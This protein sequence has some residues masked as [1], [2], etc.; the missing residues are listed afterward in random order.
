MIR[1]VPCWLSGV[2]EQVLYINGRA[3]SKPSLS[4]R[5]LALHN[6][7]TSRKAT[8]CVRSVLQLIL[9]KEGE[10]EALVC[11]GII[12]C[13]VWE[14]L[15]VL[16]GLVDR[17]FIF[18]LSK[19]MYSPPLVLRRLKMNIFFFFFNLENCA[20]KFTWY[21]WSLMVCCQWRPALF[22]GLCKLSALPE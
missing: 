19:Q 22:P 20:Y 11:I 13:W 15:F 2:P 16:W 9:S 10:V 8:V 4:N 12:L 7:V 18:E 6:L 14:I 5:N 17:S 21:S 3:V 1:M